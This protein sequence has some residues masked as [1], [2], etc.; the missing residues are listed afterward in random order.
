MKAEDFTRNRS[1]TFINLAVIIINLVRRSTQLD[2]Y[3]F[4][5][6]IGVPSITKQAFSKAR[7]KLSPML[8]QLLNEKLIQEFYT[9]NI[10][11]TFKGL[12]VL[13]V[14][15]ST[16]R[17][18]SSQELYKEYGHDKHNNS[19]PLARAS[20]IFDVLN[21]LALHASINPYFTS[22]RDLALEHINTLDDQH[23][24]LL[25]FDRG[26]AWIVLA[27]YINDR[28][29]HFL[30]RVED[31]FLAEVNAAIHSGLIDS[32]IT[33][34]AHRPGR[35]VSEKSRKYLRNIG[36]EKELQVR[37]LV[38]DLGDNKKEYIMT[39]LL[40]QQQFSYDDIFKL[41]SMR[42]NIEEGF[43]FYKTIAQIENFSGKSK[44]AI[45]Q[46]FFATLFACNLSTLLMEEAQDEL[47]EKEWDKD[48]KY[49]YKINRNIVIGV[50]KDEII[51]VFLSD[52]DLDEYCEILKDRMK[53]NLVPIRPNRSSPRDG[54]RGL[55]GLFKI[56]RKAL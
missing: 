52:R 18:P 46:D 14:D 5:D 20:V 8:F 16:L 47:K 53:Q 13:A 39:S 34:P 11:E 51:D 17:L 36:H 48:V 38:F 3:Q 50:I 37:I 45:E 35:K 30:M 28:N 21:K 33:I 4:T 7:K 56:F 40:D 19:I 43:K 15:S 29:K 44:V 27:F 12:R 1:L 9:D 6:W 41:Y 22:E 26:Y 23:I 2:L 55:G 32:I 24:D 10:I 31:V 25:L 42:W 54:R 49:D